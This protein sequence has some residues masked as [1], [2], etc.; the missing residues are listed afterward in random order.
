MPPKR[1]RSKYNKQ[2]TRHGELSYHN[3]KNPVPQDSPPAAGRINDTIPLCRCAILLERF[4]AIGKF[5]KLYYG[6]W[7]RLPK[8]HLKFACTSGA[9]L[10]IASSKAGISSRISSTET[11]HTFTLAF[12]IFL[13]RDNE[14]QALL[15]ILVMSFGP[16]S[17]YFSILYILKTTV[18]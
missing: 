11:Q 10:F 18:F 12:K 1:Q 16:L 8:Y 6:V 15:W 17:F 5:I 2:P 4:C 13:T 9:V 3:A 14:K 7:G